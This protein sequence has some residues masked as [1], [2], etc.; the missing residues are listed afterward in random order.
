MKTKTAFIMALVPILVGVVYANNVEWLENADG[1][2]PL[3]WSI[4]PL[5]PSASDVITFTIPID[6]VYGNNCYAEQ[7]FGGK[8][9]L[10]IN[11]LTKTIAIIFLPPAPQHCA[12][13]FDLTVGLTGK[14]GPL[15]PGPW[16]FEC[17]HNK[18]PFQRNF[19]VGSS[20]G[21][22]GAAIYVD[23]DAILPPNGKSW[24]SAYRNLQD[25]LAMALPG[26]TIHMA[27]G[28]YT[29]DKGAGIVPGDRKASFVIPKDVSVL[30]GFA[31]YGAPDPD[32]RD[33]EMSPTI[34]SGDL[35]QNDIW[36]VLNTWDNSYHVVTSMG[37]GTLD[38]LAI[39]AGNA[40]GYGDDG[41]GGG[42]FLQGSTLLVNDCKI[43]YNKADYGG[44]VAVHGLAPAF[45][46]TEITGNCACVHGGAIHNQ[47]AD[48]EMVNC[49]ISG[50]KAGG[51]TLMVGDAIFNVL[52]SL[53]IINCTIADNLP[54]KGSTYH[55]CAIVDLECGWGYTH[56]ITIK[57]S[58]LRNGG[59]EISAYPG[60]V[61]IHYSNIQGGQGAFSGF[62][63]IDK[64]PRFKKPGH[65]TNGCQ[66]VYERDGYCLEEG[67]PSIDAGN[68][69]Y[70]PVTILTDILG[71]ERI[72]GKEIDQ[73]AYECQG[74]K[75]AY[76]PHVL[77]LKQNEAEASILRVDLKVGKITE[78]C[79]D[80]VPVG[81]VISQHPTG[82]LPVEPGSAV[83]LVISKGP[84]LV[85][86]PDVVGKTQYAAEAM[87][88]GA[89][90]K[91][92]KVTQECSCT[93]PAGHIISQNPKG[94]TMVELCS[95][96]DLV[97][98]K[99]PAYVQVPHVVGKTQYAAEAMIIG[100]GLQVGKVTQEC[101]CTVPAGHV[102]SQNPV[103]GTSVRQCTYVDLV[104]SKGPAYVQVPYVVGQS[105][106]MAQAMIVGAGLQ[107]G[108][109]TQECSC[110]VPAGQIISQNPVG[111]TSV[112]QCSYVDLVVSKG[113]GQVQVPYVVGQ[114]QAV[115]QNI[116]LGVG[117]Q[118]GSV[119][120]AHSDTVLAGHVISQSPYAGTIVSQC[121]SVDLVLSKGPAP[122]AWDLIG[123]V[124]IYVKVPN[125]CPPYNVPVN[126]TSSFTFEASV[127]TEY[128]LEIDGVSG[129]G[130]SWHVT[131]ENGST[132]PGV[133]TILFQYQGVNVNLSSLPPGNQIVAAVKIFTRPH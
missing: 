70:F 87:I 82:G 6:Q 107:V 55:R 42:L 77:L 106:Y 67:S 97:I 27:D 44:G 112:K 108:K 16:I 86:V 40:D 89:G 46:N 51:D 110:T 131:P 48:I 116:I 96:V 63:N 100:A 56:K 49:L 79:S 128:R 71:Q 7:H 101:S 74:P 68:K 43:Q 130:G 72:Q 2:I 41:Y 69:T 19:L 15:A 62:G 111:G 29:P 104:V 20:G 39:M 35:L 93:V 126:G 34:L 103:G 57:N 109:V 75:H 8:P 17:I 115:A 22:P 60:V 113:P 98:S 119:T 90:L 25:A 21:S 38:G 1:I 12:S 105:Q 58:I 14:F 94:G 88:V 50:N 36:C 121:S 132:P 24:A 23:K 31:G 123:C 53:D 76:V 117:L 11:H 102:I 84:C 129:V 133:K 80:T 28:T 81:C 13:V 92:G 37:P 64:D 54:D 33:S 99:G 127:P 9:H 120:Q 5:N 10:D 125:P 118:V 83:D 61:T 4:A 30:G 32:A 47:Q 45:I 85:K 3:D 95:T 59:K 18:V 52:G 78:E 26:V 66:W 65:Y 114:S 73:G 122:K 91:V 124:N